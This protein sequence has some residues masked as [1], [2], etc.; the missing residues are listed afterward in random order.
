MVETPKLHGRI[1]K[2]D[3]SIVSVSIVGEVVDNMLGFPVPFRELYTR[4]VHDA[5]EELACF[6]KAGTYVLSHVGQIV[7]YIADGNAPM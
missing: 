7:S 4:N 6:R 1:T 3:R 5:R 2:P